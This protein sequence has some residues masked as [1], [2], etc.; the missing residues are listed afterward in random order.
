M[1]STLDMDVTAAS[2]PTA[3]ELSLY[4]SWSARFGAWLID[5]MLML[6]AVVAM[7]A[8][9]ET[10]GGLAVFLLPPV[11]ATVCHGGRSGQSVGKRIVG[12]SVR[13]ASSLGRIGYG[14]AFGRWLVTALLWVLVLPGLLDALWPLRDSKRQAW[15]DK[16]IHSV[17]IRL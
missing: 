12:I 14:P 4:A 1:E 17:V 3:T 10:A 8:V 11:Y 6:V 7:S 5:G 9:S 13:D 16:A 15:H 2:A